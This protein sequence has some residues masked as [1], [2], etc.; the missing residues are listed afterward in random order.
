[1]LNSLLEQKFGH[2]IRVR[3]CGFLVEDDEIL[4]LNH[5]GIGKKGNLWIPPGGAVE[6]GDSLEETLIREFREETGLEVKITKS[7]FNLEYIEPPLHAIEFF[8]KVERVSGNLTVGID[9]E[10]DTEDQIISQVGFFNESAI[11]KIGLDYLHYSFSCVKN[12]LE[13]LNLEKHIIYQ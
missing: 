1:M 8:Y 12:P 7:M 4:L 10:L 13:V 6:F 2:K 11:N 9:P 3:A 5:Q